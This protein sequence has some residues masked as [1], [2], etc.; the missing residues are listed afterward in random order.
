MSSG[1]AVIKLREWTRRYLPAEVAGSVTALASAL[2]AR[3]CGASYILAAV[4]GSLGE[5][6]GFYGYFLICGTAQHYRTSHRLS[7]FTRLKT[8]VSLTLRDILIEFSVAEAVDSLLLRPFL[9]FL[10]P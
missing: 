2:V 8:A 9:M 4:I 6:V 3:T 10:M 5:N 7:G 1:H